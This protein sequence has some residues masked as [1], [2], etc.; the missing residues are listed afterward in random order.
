MPLTLV[1]DYIFFFGYVLLDKKDDNNIFGDPG[2]LAEVNGE[3]T[4]NSSL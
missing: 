2:E 1:S 3:T 4:T